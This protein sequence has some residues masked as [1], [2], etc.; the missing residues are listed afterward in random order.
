MRFVVASAILSFGSAG[1]C[2]TAA[3][4]ATGPDA[5][6]PRTLAMGE[7][8]RAAATGSLST[9]LNP[10]G[11]VLTKSYVLE[12]SYGYRPEDHANIQAV[13]VCDSVTTRIGACLYY[14]H[15]SADFTLDGQGSRYR[16]EF[17]L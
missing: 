5:V 4:Q 7:S 2:A 10:A 13:S 1:L 17:G 11:V 8:L 9:I 12:G 15:L 16:H 14:D 3:A 6:S